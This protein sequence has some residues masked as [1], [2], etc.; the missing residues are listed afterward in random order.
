MT[1]T[2]YHI[3]DFLRTFENIQLVAAPTGTCA[4]RGDRLVLVISTPNS[5][6]LPSRQTFLS[7]IW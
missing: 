6:D 2:I 1:E 7:R 3:Q 4:S 5:E